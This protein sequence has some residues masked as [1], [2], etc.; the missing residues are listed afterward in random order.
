MSSLGNGNYTVKVQ[1]A[2]SVGYGAASTPVGPITVPAVSPA[3][4]DPPTVFAPTIAIAADRSAA[5]AIALDVSWPAATDTGG[6]ISGYELEAR[7]DGGSWSAVDLASPS[8]T[9][10]QLS[11]SPGQ[12]V[13]LRLAAQ[14]SSGNWSGWA[15]LASNPVS[16]RVIQEKPTANVVY[17]GR[18]RRFSFAGALGGHVR[19]SGHANH[20]VTFTF[21]GSSVAFVSTLSS[22]RG[23]ASVQL[24]GGAA[25]LID[26][27]LA[28]GY[29][30]ARV[31][32]ASGPLS[33]GPH[34]LVITVTGTRNPSSRR[35]RVDIDAFLVL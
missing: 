24:D 9:G 1:A 35:N 20:K 3:D 13:D 14:D 22:A 28:G 27:Y 7:L 18:F 15:H 21:T 17:H 8:A 32:W 31:A 29:Q 11:V 4:T 12:T 33:A 25:Q 2:N 5:G 6:P 26:L 30:M 16:V 10:V 34:T 19:A 23:I